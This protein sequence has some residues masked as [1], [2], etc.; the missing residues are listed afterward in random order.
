MEIACLVIAGVLVLLGIVGCFV[1]VLPGPL[2]AYCGLLCMLPTAHSPSALTLVLFGLAILIVSVLDYVFP[3]VG[4]KKFNCSRLGTWGCVVGTL[5]GLFFFPLGLL[6]GPFAGAFAG[7]L[8][9]HKSFKA[10]LWGGLG[11]FLGFL[12]GLA[13]KTT[14]CLAVLAYFV[15]RLLES[16]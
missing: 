10:A 13:V 16:C 8:I 12:S 1:P 11:A 7:E 5:V 4:A 6:V 2:L 15:W 9:A 3:A 14:A